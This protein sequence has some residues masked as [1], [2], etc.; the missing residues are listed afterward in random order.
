M[1]IW[2]GIGREMRGLFIAMIRVVSNTCEGPKILFFLFRSQL[3]CCSLL[4]LRSSWKECS[5]NYFALMEFSE[6][7]KNL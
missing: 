3:V 6:V 2:G 1:E 4:D 5:A 7:T